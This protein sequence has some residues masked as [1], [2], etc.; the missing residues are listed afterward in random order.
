[1]RMVGGNRYIASYSFQSTL[2]AS[3]VTAS[4][5]GTGNM[6]R[7]N[8]EFSLVAKRTT[9]GWTNLLVTQRK[10]FLSNAN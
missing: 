5:S 3:T 4:G 2:N 9:Q 8:C 1:M 7:A 6:Y 10:E